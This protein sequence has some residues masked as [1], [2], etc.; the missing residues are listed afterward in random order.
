MS[1]CREQR[2]RYSKWHKIRR[3]SSLEVKVTRHCDETARGENSLAK[4]N[5][6]VC[7]HQ[8]GLEHAPKFESKHTLIKSYIQRLDNGRCTR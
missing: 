1:F 8:E 3:V 2:V 5:Y 7:N 6:T 4:A